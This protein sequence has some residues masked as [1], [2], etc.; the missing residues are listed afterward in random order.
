MIY[1]PV[2]VNV[3]RVIYGA[4]VYVAVTVCWDR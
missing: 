2:N 4:M 1:I 3:S